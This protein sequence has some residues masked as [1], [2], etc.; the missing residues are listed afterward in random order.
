MN[1]FH[2]GYW[3]ALRPGPLS[4]FA[5]K[6]FILT[7]IASMALFFLLT[8][9]IKIK[10]DRH[11]KKLFRKINSLILSNIFILSILFFFMY[12]ETPF[13]GS[14]AWVLFVLFEALFWLFFIIKF[15]ITIPG[16]RLKNIEQKEYDKYIP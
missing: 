1:I 8:F 15:Y 16:E 9:L 11:T 5:I 4:P 14:R 10:K 7:L 2:L 12:E 3:F 6:T 13:L